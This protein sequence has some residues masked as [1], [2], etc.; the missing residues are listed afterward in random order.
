MITIIHG[1]DLASSRNYFLELKL[2]QK[3]AIIYDGSKVTITEL[4]QDIEGSGLFNNSKTIFIEEILTKTKKTDKNVKEILNFIAKNSFESTFVLWESK[5]I[6][7]RDLSIFNKALVKFFKLPKN[8]FVFLDNLRPN[9]SRNLLNL[10]HQAIESGIKEELILFMLQRQI[11]ILLG[12]VDP[13]SDAP[14][15]ELSRLAPWQRDKLQVQARYFDQTQ[16][17][18]IYKKLF[19]IEVGQ[20]TGGLSLSLVQAIDFLLLD[21]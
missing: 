14:I 3:N 6:S 13:S 18:K 11:R 9:N 1:D 8:I 7:K 19:K 2:Q 16:L 21:I 5:E 15:E 10:F 17:K 4:V 20:K 12:L